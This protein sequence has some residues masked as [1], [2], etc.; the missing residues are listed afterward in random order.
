MTQFQS[1]RL[2][3]MGVVCSISA[4]AQPPH[5]AEAVAQCAHV[6]KLLVAKPAYPAS[7]ARPQTAFV[8]VEFTILATGH[9]IDAEVVSS[10]N[11]AL[12]ARAL[13]DV[14]VLVFDRSKMS[15]RTRMTVH[16]GPDG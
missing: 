15:C 12:N 4:C 6:P 10:S 2:F 5:A 14:G 16:Y 8:V 9:V 1:R 7:T 11:S 3:A 13:R